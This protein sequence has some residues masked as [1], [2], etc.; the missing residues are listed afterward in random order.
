[1]TAICVL[2][3]VVFGVEGL[4]IAISGVLRWEVLD[5]SLQATL[6][7]HPLG[8]LIF[9]SLR[10]VLPIEIGHCVILIGVKLLL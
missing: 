5:G 4:G 3:I 7:R 10:L 8:A 2:F 9:G 1:M 6:G